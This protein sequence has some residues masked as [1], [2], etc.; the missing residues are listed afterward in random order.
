MTRQGL[1]AFLIIMFAM[2]AMI[3]FALGFALSGPIA[4]LTLGGAMLILPVALLGLVSWFLSAVARWGDMAAHYPSTVPPPPDN[5]MEP[6][7]TSIALRWRWFGINNC[8]EWRADDDYLHLVFALPF[9]R[10]TPPVSIPWG[11]T[12]ITLVNK[13]T[14]RL[15][16][17]GFSLWVPEALVKKELALRAGL[18]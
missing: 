11:E 8:V 12:E 17:G 1:K 18:Q 14:F 2:D 15:D 5:R 4:G 6:L 7:L 13:K 9:A 10:A 3:G 16:A